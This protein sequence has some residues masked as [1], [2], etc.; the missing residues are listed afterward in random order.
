MA[1]KATRNMPFSLVFRISGLSGDGDSVEIST[2]FF[3]GMGWCVGIEILFPRQ[4]RIQFWS[5]HI[6]LLVPAI[7]EAG[8]NRFIVPYCDVPVIVASVR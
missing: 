5:P 7:S 4:P 3:V 1:F 8:E 6:T 2:D